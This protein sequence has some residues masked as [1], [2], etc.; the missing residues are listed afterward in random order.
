MSLH[1]LDLMGQVQHYAAPVSAELLEM[2]KALS[3]QNA[4][5]VA[6]PVMGRPKGVPRQIAELL[7]ARRAKPGQ[8]VQVSGGRGKSVR[9]QIAEAKP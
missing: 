2:R 4:A 3:P 5:K 6:A 9:T 7:E 8:S 1:R